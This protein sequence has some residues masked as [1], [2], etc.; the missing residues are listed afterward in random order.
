MISFLR[1]G[2]AFRAAGIALAGRPPAD[3]RSV[4]FAGAGP[5][6]GQEHQNGRSVH[7]R[8]GRDRGGQAGVSR[9]RN[10]R[11]FRR[12]SFRTTVQRVRQLARQTT[13]V[14]RI[15]RYTGVEG[16]PQLINVLRGD[17]SLGDMSLFD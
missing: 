7:Q 17:M 9:C 2:T 8:D 14:G 1:R 10:G 5:L 3:A 11:L 15:I 4:C 6:V 12:L 16:L 13:R